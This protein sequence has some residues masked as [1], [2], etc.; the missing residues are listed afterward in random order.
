MYLNYF[1]LVER[2]FSIAPDP[3]YLY[4]SARHREAMAHLSYGLSQGGCFIVLTGEVGT[5]KTTLWISY[6]ELQ[7]KK[8]LLD[9][10]NDYL[11]TTYSENRHTVLIIDE[12]Q[13]L[14]RTVLEQV[15]LLTNLETTKSKL[16]QIIL[17]GQ[18]ELN[19][20]LGRNDLRQLAQ[21]VT[22]RYHLPAIS[23][24]EIQE[25]VNFRLSVAGCKKPLFSSQALKYLHNLSGGIPRKINVMADQALLATYA[26]SQLVVDSSTIKQAAKDVLV[27][28]SGKGV[29]NL[30]KPNKV[31][32]AIIAAA[33]LML[34]IGLWWWFTGNDSS[35]IAAVQNSASQN[36]AAAQQTSSGQALSKS[37]AT[38]QIDLSQ[39]AKP[40][41]QVSTITKPSNVTPGSVVIADEFLD[42]EVAAADTLVATNGNSQRGAADRRNVWAGVGSL[43]RSYRSHSRL[44]KFGRGLGCGFTRQYIAA[45]V[46]WDK[47][48]RRRVFASL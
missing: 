7:S 30:A 32:W 17:I 47:T 20:L 48:T 14:S 27:K 28:S 5:G 18:P 11:L 26:K 44:Q 34:N 16:L 8:R 38:Q 31:V 10:I 40:A 6:P 29:A 23:K 36:N 19:D 25:Y 9:S 22:A 41:P 45:S 3:Q 37:D 42:G 2:P 39:L 21:R 13:L 46:Y 15:R 24:D 4:M 33:I 12:A 35:E 43:T 1:G